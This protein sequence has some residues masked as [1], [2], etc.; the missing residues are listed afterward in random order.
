MGTEGAP[1][2]PNSSN[3]IT[4]FEIEFLLS[5]VVL[6][7]PWNGSLFVSYSNCAN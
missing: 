1:G 2:M 4:L 3:S 5:K 6:F 7:I